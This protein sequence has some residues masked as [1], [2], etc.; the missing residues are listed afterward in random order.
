M[1]DMPVVKTR[2]MHD[3][4]LKVVKAHQQIREHI[5]ERAREIQNLRT[6]QAEHAQSN[7]IVVPYGT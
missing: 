6:Q 4:I 7:E 1:A 5:A 2:D 3:E